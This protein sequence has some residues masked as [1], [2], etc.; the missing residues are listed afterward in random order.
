MNVQSCFETLKESLKEKIE[1]YQQ[2]INDSDIMDLSKYDLRDAIS[3]C[4]EFK[5]YRYMPANYYNIRNI[6]T[7]T[8]HLSTNGVMNDLYEG[9]PI[10]NGKYTCDTIHQLGD[11][12]LLLCLTETNKD[13]LMWSH[14]ADSHRGICIEYDLKKLKD[15]NFNLLNHLFPVIYLDKRFI[16]RNVESLVES[17]K[18]LKQSIL[19]EEE[20]YGEESLDDIIPLFINKGKMWEYEKEWRIIFT[21]KHLYDIDNQ[22]LYRGN[23]KFKCISAV[24]LGYRIDSEMKKNIIEICDRISSPGNEIKV[25]QEIIDSSGYKIDFE[26]VC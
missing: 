6:E 24:Y 7:Q 5:L 1:Y 16:Y 23:I 11:L 9:L 10:D 2:D 12:A 14:Y 26:P 15:D 13:S 20:Y 21:M 17:H 25:Y 8:I 3:D 18:R 4:N 19:N 22:T